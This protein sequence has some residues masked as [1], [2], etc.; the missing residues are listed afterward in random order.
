[1][2]NAEQGVLDYSFE[3]TNA[4]VTSLHL[5]TQGVPARIFVTVEGTAIRYRYTGLAPEP[6]V[7]GGH[8]IESGGAV[9]IEG[10]KNIENFRMIA[11]TGI[12]ADVFI[13]LE[14]Q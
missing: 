7:G 9:T 1:M 3:V 12:N 14:I 11:Q 13:T 5:P 8:P 2:V 6:G 4:A 10:P